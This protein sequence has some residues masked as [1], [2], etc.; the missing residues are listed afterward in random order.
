M[1]VVS[2]V[3]VIFICTPFFGSHPSLSTLVP[4]SFTGGHV[5]VFALEEYF[6]EAQYTN[7]LAVG[8]YLATVGQ[9]VSFVFGVCWINIAQR[10]GLLKAR[11]SS[12]E[13][14]AD[15]AKMFARGFIPEG[16]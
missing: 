2:T 10:R 6:V 3:T 1:W 5:V 7:G 15:D 11:A 13:Q 8:L 14:N 4:G 9:I 16:Q 12:A